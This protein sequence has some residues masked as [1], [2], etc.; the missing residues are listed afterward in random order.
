VFACL[1]IRCLFLVVELQRQL[2]VPWGLSIGN[3]PH[4]SANTRGGRVQ[5]YVVKRIDEVGPELQPE[6]L[7]QQEVLLQTQV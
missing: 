7:C 3:L 6:P 4:A 2:D 1:I 5:L